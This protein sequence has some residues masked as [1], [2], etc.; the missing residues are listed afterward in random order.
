MIKSITNFS[1]L[2]IWFRLFLQ[3]LCDWFESISADVQ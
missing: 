3:K 1:I 2:D